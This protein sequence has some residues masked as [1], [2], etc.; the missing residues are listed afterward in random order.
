MESFYETGCDVSTLSVK[1]NKKNLILLSSPT[2][3][4][5]RTN[6]RISTSLD[7]GKSWRLGPLVDDKASYSDLVQAQNGKV[8]ILYE[9]TGRVFQFKIK[10]IYYRSF[11]LDEF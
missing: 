10:G 5:K 7:N 3:K 9:H 6:L 11:G 1:H 2:N 4:K 8:G